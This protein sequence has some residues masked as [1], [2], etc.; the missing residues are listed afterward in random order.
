MHLEGIGRTMAPV[1]NQLT[2]QSQPR[3]W[4]S[5]ASLDAPAHANAAGD[6]A[7]SA[8]ANL[9]SRYKVVSH[10]GT[11]G[12]GIVFKVRDLD[13]G[14][15]VALKMLKPGM[16]SAQAMQE[17]LR[18]EVCLARKVTHKN[19][20]RIYE[21][22]RS[23][24]AAC[25]SMEFVEG[26][27]LLSKLRG[28][29][30][31][32]Q[33]EALDIARQI[34]AGLREAHVQGIVHRDLKPANIMVDHSGTVKIMDFGIARL[35]EEDGQMTGTIA[36][37]PAYMAPEQLELKAMGPQTDIYALGLLLYEM[38]TG[39]P[40]FAGDTPIGTALKQIR[41]LPKRPS[42]IVATIPA[43]TEAI[44]LK[45]LR[46][47][48]ARRYQSVDELDAALQD[49]AS[50]GLT[51]PRLAA[52][53]TAVAATLENQLKRLEQNRSVRA[54]LEHLRASAPVFRALAFEVRRSSMDASRA[55]SRVVRQRAGQAGEF[56][57]AQDWRA[58]TK[59]RAG[60]AVAAVLGCV[61][62]L[63]LAASRK[64]HANNELAAI[65][66]AAPATQNS[67][68]L[69]SKNGF[70]SAA[71]GSFPNAE[72]AFGET[73]NPAPGSASTH[74]ADLGRDTNEA[75]TP[76]SSKNT[77]K[78]PSAS[79]VSSAPSR[80]AAAPNGNSR[81]PL[82]K[83]LKPST[84]ASAKPSAPA[85]P[86]GG[87]KIVGPQPDPVAP[88]ILAATPAVTP[89]LVDPAEQQKPAQTAMY[90]EV[91]SFKD[92]NWA[93]H[94]VEKLSALGY[95]AISVHQTR[96]WMQSFHVQVGPYADLKDVDM[97][98]KGLASQGFKTHLVK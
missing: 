13:T 68:P 49:E 61:L 10:I 46:K 39:A 43:R 75:D 38:V 74:D 9:P 59:S 14:E 54:G 20:C 34:C 69:H 25:I 52:L 78:A 11:G 88:A 44:I 12:M 84:L 37:T 1:D 22:N 26:E 7:Q 18:K 3:Q 4:L 35:T 63:G 40:A 50:A 32:P 98:Q 80:K 87:E 48:P 56:L 89:K 31:L 16:A 62:V 30:A 21:F 45:C 81:T 8:I 24:G 23:D 96:L 85:G 19:V 47:D 55:V 70:S 17:N 28:A 65:P 36:G 83:K 91:G 79:S 97:A 64:G 2:R 76:A 42:E 82:S 93:Q 92:S 6:Y 90:L 67:Q 29:G 72:S 60:Q 95:H 58:A 15:I 27:S 51:A 94:A 5:E 86:L 66:I 41:E 73:T 33:N 77:V 57:R 71:A 53:S